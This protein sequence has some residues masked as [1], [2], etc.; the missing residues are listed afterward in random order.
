MSS[1]QNTL[2]ML[3]RNKIVSTI[4]PTTIDKEVMEPDSTSSWSPDP[5][6]INEQWSRIPRVP[7]H[8][9]ITE[10]EREGE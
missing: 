3:E 8:R 10:K 1:F 7:G 5:D 9:K 6:N 4:D 2:V